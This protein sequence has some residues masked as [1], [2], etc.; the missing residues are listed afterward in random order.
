MLAGGVR[1]RPET[2]ADPSIEGAYTVNAG[3]YLVSRFDTCAFGTA[4]RD[5]VAGVERHVIAVVPY[6]LKGPSVHVPDEIP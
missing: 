4:R 2:L 5:E 1:M 3:P 6:Q